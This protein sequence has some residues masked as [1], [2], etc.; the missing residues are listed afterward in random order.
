[1]Q[2]LGEDAL[3]LGGYESS[4]SFAL[5]RDTSACGKMKARARPR[6]GRGRVCAKTH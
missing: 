2:V 6:P 3:E 1:M 4:E 5:L